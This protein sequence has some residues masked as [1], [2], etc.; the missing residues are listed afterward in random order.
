MRINFQNIYF[1]PIKTKKQQKAQ[2]MSLP[3]IKNDVFESKLQT[4]TGMRC[5]PNSFKI[6][7]LDDLRCPA[8]GLVMLNGEQQ[9]KFINDIHL[10]TGQDLIE[11]LEKYEDESIILKDKSKSK[12]RTIYRPLKQ[13]VV[14][15]IKKLALQ[16]PDKKIDELVK[17]EAQSALNELISKQLIIVEELENY[18]NE[19][20]KS[21]D[22]WTK[23]FEII[24]TYKAQITGEDSE[25]FQRKKFIYALSDVTQD[26]KIQEEINKIISKLPNSK[27]E[28][29][30]FFVK[31]SRDKSAKEIASKFVYESRSSA[32]HLVPQAKN[33]KDNTANYIC[34]CADCN[35]NRGNIDFHIWMKDI[36]DFEKNLQE[37]LEEVRNALDDNR[38]DYKYETYIEDIIATIKELSKGEIKLYPPE[39]KD[40]SKKGIMLERR[41]KEIRRIEQEIQNQKQEKQELKDEIGILEKHPQYK[42]VVQLK[43]TEE[44][45]KETKTKIKSFQTKACTSK[46]CTTQIQN[47][48]RE[49]EIKLARL[50]RKR[51]I[52][53]NDIDSTIDIEKRIEEKET[54]ILS[55]NVVLD[56]IREL[57]A[58]IKEEDKLA[59]RKEFLEKENQELRLK[60][61]N[62]FRTRKIDA[63]TEEKYQRALHYESLLLIADENIEILNTKKRKQNK[64]MIEL[65][66]ISKDVL[67]RRLA[68]LNIQPGT[69]YY[70]N[71]Q[72]IEA[73]ETEIA[74]AQKKLD[75]IA[76][77]KEMIKVLEQQ[78][79]K[80]GGGK[81]IQQLTG[82][83]QILLDERKIIEKIKDIDKL[84]TK[85]KQ[86]ED[87][88]SYNE[89]IFGQL[90]NYR[91]MTSEKFTSLTDRIYC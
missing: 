40:L 24:N 6:K 81:T 88:I 3:I 52:I 48:L 61:E 12:G 21:N 41:R 77:I 84:R 83:L 53:Q 66:E 76:T 8:C 15:V 43:R 74:A 65:L 1:T 18:V 17:I 79:I 72:K 78:A 85:L 59:Q 9:K 49:L 39:S 16:Y 70:R 25:Q 86:L 11:A 28:I 89:G 46:T 47:N 45:I 62:I 68:T 58:Q 26:E 7:E 37:Y 32:E 19:N 63:N 35:S 30:S 20:V 14:N 64:D 13:E 42:N 60:N 5:S 22:E 10:K 75:E 87:T 91:T 38:L 55:V 29:N 69:Q 73:N 54:Q 50:E 51:E 33:G 44:Q 23:I 56:N 34:D 90:F 82:E 36:P 27:N 31:Y 80:N 2:Y 4:F 57:T 67:E 71:A